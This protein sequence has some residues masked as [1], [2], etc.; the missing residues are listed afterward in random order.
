[1]KTLKQSNGKWV[2]FVLFNPSYCELMIF[3]QKSDTKSTENST[4]SYILLK[5]AS[6]YRMFSIYFFFLKLVVVLEFFT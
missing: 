5:F 1:M 4:F 6:N 2:K 3:I